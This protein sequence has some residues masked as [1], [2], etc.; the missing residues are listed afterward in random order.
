VRVTWLLRFWFV[1]G[2]L[3]VGSMTPLG[4]PLFLL[5]LVSIGL[6]QHLTR[7]EG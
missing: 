7:N 3:V 4:G 6:F 1:V 5:L 2:A